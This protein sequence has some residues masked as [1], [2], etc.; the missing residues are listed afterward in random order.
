MARKPQLPGAN[1][2]FKTSSGS[3]KEEVDPPAKPVSRATAKTSTAPRKKA[4]E[5]ASEPAEVVQTQEA[6]TEVLPAV[7]ES[8]ASPAALF[9]VSISPKL[10]PAYIRAAAKPAPPRAMPQPETEKVTFYVPSQMLQQLEICRV[11]LLTEHNIKVG[12]SQIV[13]AAIA[14]SAHD[15]KL[16]AQTLDELAHVWGADDQ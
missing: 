1:D 12:R 11:R 10:D 7:I 9:P 2:F 16:I 14:L 4:D 13:Q 8:A 5:P 15:P 3:A 6:S